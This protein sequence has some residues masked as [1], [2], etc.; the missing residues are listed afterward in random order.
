M[1]DK[2]KFQLAIARKKRNLFY[3]SDKNLDCCTFCFLLHKAAIDVYI[4]KQ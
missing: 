1:T 4:I 3:T 2:C